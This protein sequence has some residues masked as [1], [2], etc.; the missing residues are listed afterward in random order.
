VSEL[1]VV[2]R[3][4]DRS[5]LLL[6]M[7]VLVGPGASDS[8]LVYIVP[9]MWNPSGCYSEGTPRITSITSITNPIEQQIVND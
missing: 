2:V 1:F 4:D 8:R 6:D 3:I 9:S 5:Y 7:W